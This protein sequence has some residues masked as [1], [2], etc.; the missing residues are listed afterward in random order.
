MRSW[1]RY[2]RLIKTQLQH[3]S[4]SENNIFCKDGNGKDADFPC[5]DF[6][7]HLLL[8]SLRWDA[9]DEN[10]EIGKN[11]FCARRWHLYVL[12]TFV[13][14]KT[15][16]TTCCRMASQSAM[17]AKP[18][19]KFLASSTRV[20]AFIW[21]DVRKNFWAIML[22]DINACHYRLLKSDFLE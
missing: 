22:I 17:N 8:L 7:Y 6:L 18:G 19:M 13:R 5:T 2:E 11:A 10:R 1:N 16:E 20:G 12:S 3:W 4:V 21:S 15:R 14:S 9:F